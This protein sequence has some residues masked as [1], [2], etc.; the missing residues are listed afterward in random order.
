MIR[1]A[2]RTDLPRTEERGG[3][4]A[5]T[6][7]LGVPEGGGPHRVERVEDIDRAEQRIIRAAD[8]VGAVAASAVVGWAVAPRPMRVRHRLDRRD[9]RPLKVGLDGR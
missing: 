6:V 4:E 3:E 8:R 1:T 7:I 9:R 5:L 2:G